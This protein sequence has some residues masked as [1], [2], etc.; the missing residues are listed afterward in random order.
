MKEI[1]KLLKRYLLKE[2]ATLN[3]ITDKPKAKRKN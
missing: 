1:L 3:Q 2:A